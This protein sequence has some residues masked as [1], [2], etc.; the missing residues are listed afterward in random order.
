[1]LTKTA[2]TSALAQL[3]SLLRRERKIKQQILALNDGVARAVVM[4][5]AVDIRAA[6]KW[7]DWCLQRV[8]LLR[9]ELQQLAP[10]LDCARVTA[11]RARGRHQVAKKLWDAELAALRKAK[12]RRIRDLG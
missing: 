1:V 8:A 6:G 5:D 10:E 3:G 2:Q 12:Q 4:S 9:D 7:S 11:R